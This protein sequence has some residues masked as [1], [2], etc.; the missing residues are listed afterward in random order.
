MA[1]NAGNTQLVD[2]SSLTLSAYGMYWLNNEKRY[3]VG[4]R[5]FTWYKNLLE[6]HINPVLGAYLISE[7]ENY[8]AF[9]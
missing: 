7:H 2:N 9:S 8:P 1:N 4:E 5:T 6:K 3:E